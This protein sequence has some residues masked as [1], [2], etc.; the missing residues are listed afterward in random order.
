MGYNYGNY[1]FS[2]ICPSLY[3]L[4]CK[5]ET[6]ENA[7]ECKIWSTRAVQ[8]KGRMTTGYSGSS[9]LSSQ[10]CLRDLCDSSSV[11]ELFFV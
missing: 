11:S 6:K 4:T 7:I 9:S 10:N 1:V 5:H 8:A 3:L 2:S